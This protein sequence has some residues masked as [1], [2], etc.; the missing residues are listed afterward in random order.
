MI[1]S[2]N[3][4][5]KRKLGIRVKVT[6]TFYGVFIDLLQQYNSKIVEY[7][8]Q[9]VHIWI[10][11]DEQ[12]ATYIAPCICVYILMD[13]V[14]LS[15]VARIRCTV[16]ATCWRG[17]RFRNCRPVESKHIASVIHIQQYSTMNVY[18]RDAQRNK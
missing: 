13:T 15:V 4:R 7:T 16:V 10:L 8:I 14:C 17:S 3:I 9:F 1:Y 2:A 5:C 12:V 18:A 11:K 6:A